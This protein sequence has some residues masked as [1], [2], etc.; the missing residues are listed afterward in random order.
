MIKTVQNLDEV[1]EFAWELSQNK[2]Y[3]SYPRQNSRD[4]IKEEIEKAIKLENFN[5]IAFYHKSE[6]CGVCS[7]FW[8]NG[9]KYVQTTIFL[10]SEGYKEIIDKFINYISNELPGYELFIGVPSTNRSINEYFKEKNIKC[11]EDSIVTRICNLK[12]HS[13]KGYEFIEEIK[14][15][16][17]EEYALFHDKYAVPNEIYFNSK[18]LYKEIEHFRIFAYKQDDEIHGSIFVK[19][20]KEI[21]DVIGLFID[22]EYK[23]KD[24][25]SILINE[26]MAGLYNEFG[27]IKEVLYFIDKDSA[28]ELDIA[29]EAG[30]RI[31]EEYRLFK[32]IL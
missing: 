3:A 21:A 14:K 10:I 7:Y 13:N 9:E 8:I 20:C 28:D 30:F 25:E 16:N 23:N 4:E 19:A 29:L 11:V 26:M 22:K 32:C 2:L 17:F 5:I 24:I 6:L 15:N 18:N 31:K 27:L 12:P 1:A